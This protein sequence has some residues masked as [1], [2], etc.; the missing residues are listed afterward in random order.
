MRLWLSFMIVLILATSARAEP[1]TYKPEGCAFE[2]TFPSQPE[3]VERCNSYLPDRCELMTNFTHVFDLTATLNFFVTCKMVD[4]TVYSDFTQDIMRTTLIARAGNRLETF[5]T[6]FDARDDYKTAALLGAG[7][8]PNGKDMMMY[9]SQ[10]WIGKESILT[11]ESELIGPQHEDAERMFAAILQS[12][13]HSA[14]APDKNIRE[15]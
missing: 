12:I 13:Q 14:S 2:I 15:E 9:M 4:E 5:E 8:S 11:V 3:T 1:Y 6:Y 10:L 7:N